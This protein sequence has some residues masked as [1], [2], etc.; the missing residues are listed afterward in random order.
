[1][2]KEV[3]PNTG[4]SGQGGE[5]EATR[6]PRKWGWPGDTQEGSHTDM[7]LKPGSERWASMCRWKRQGGGWGCPFQGVTWRVES[8]GSRDWLEAEERG[9]LACGG[10][11]VSD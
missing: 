1:M 7:A 11:R 8:L 5:W 10:L 2:W 4:V 9:G 6:E 3:S